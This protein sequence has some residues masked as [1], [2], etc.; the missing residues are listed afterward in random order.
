MIYII[1]IYESILTI[2]GTEE[3]WIMLQSVRWQFHSVILPFKRQ[4]S[5]KTHIQFVQIHFKYATLWWE[6]WAYAR[7]Q[8]WTSWPPLINLYDW[9]DCIVI[10]IY[11]MAKQ[12]DWVGG[13]SDTDHYKTDIRIWYR[14]ASFVLI[15]KIK[16]Y[17]P[18]LE[19]IMEMS[20][21]GSN[22][23]LDSRHTPIAL[24]KSVSKGRDLEWELRR[25]KWIVC[26]KWH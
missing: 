26:E 5:L 3:Q 24:W 22:I 25:R 6:T 9:Q 18:R 8:I 4:K 21:V 17:P 16:L 1:V 12:L 23:I 20:R 14:P 2:L 15:F 7:I 13:N 10:Y 19:I 11:K